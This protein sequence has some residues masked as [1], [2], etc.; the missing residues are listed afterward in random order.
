M[1][2]RLA[3]HADCKQLSHIALACAEGQNEGFTFKLGRRFLEQYYRV[4]LREKHSVV[5][6]AVDNADRVV[7]FAAGSLDAAETMRALRR[8]RLQLSLAAAWGV[9]RQPRLISGLLSRYRAVKAGTD[10]EGYVV[11]SGPRLIYWG[12]LPEARVGPG[13]LIL[14]HHCLNL[15]RS[16]G[17]QRIRAEIDSENRR[18]QQANSL[19]GAKTI[20]QFVTPDGRSRII[21]EFS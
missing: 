11:S 17:A 19:L 7:G 16:L 13:G 9:V 12:I 1:K 2:F 3:K 5:M 8:H 21:I 18:A 14:L 15:M 10:D 20:R 6:C 4:L